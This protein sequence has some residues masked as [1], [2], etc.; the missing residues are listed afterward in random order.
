M[1]ETIAMNYVANYL[2]PGPDTMPAYRTKA[3]TID[4]GAVAE[5]F[6]EG[7]EL[8]GLHPSAT[9]QI[10][11]LMIKPGATLTLREAPL[12]IEAPAETIAASAAYHRVLVD[13]GAVKPRRDSVDARIIAGVRDGTGRMRLT[14]PEDGWP[15]LQSTSPP[16]DTD[17]DGLPDVWEVTHGLNSADPTDAAQVT[18]DGWTNLENWLNS[19]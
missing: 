4:K 3:F 5:L 6:L 17:G 16:P 8:E 1:P 14:I 12:E 11:L 19:L 15:L 10:D 18:S 13:V 9:A 2:K 7:N